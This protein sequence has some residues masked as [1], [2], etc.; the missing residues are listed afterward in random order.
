MQ[1]TSNNSW[2]VDINYVRRHKDTYI[3][4]ELVG[5]RG[6]RVADCYK[7]ELEGSVIEQRDTQYS[8]LPPTKK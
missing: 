5:E 6:G 3:P 7:N 4:L 1:Y 8:L 2:L